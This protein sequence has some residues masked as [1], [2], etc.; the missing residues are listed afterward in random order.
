M[1]VDYGNITQNKANDVNKIGYIY[2]SW[3]WCHYSDQMCRSWQKYEHML[4][5]LLVKQKSGI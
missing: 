3:F 1:K 2:G 5:R 4:D